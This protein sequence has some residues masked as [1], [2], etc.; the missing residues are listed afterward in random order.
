MRFLIGFGC[1]VAATVLFLVEPNPKAP[2]ETVD[3]VASCVRKHWQGKPVEQW[4]DA[5]DVAPVCRSIL[6]HAREANR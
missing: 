6:N 2:V 4:A 5:P 1:A 3:T